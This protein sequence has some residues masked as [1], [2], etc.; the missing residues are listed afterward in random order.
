MRKKNINHRVGKELTVGSYDYDGLAHY[1]AYNYGYKSTGGSRMSTSGNLL[2]SYSAV[3]ATMHPP[4]RAGATPFV[5]I[6]INK[7]TPTTA[8]HLDCVE[9]AVSHMDHMRVDDANPDGKSDHDRN[10]KVMFDTAMTAS[11]K[12]AR[13]RS[14]WSINSHLRTYYTMVSNAK[15]YAQYFKMRNNKY[16]KRLLE[17]PDPSGEHSVEELKLIKD[18]MDKAEKAE[19][20]KRIRDIRKQDKENTDRADADLQEWLKGAKK[21]PNSHYLSQVYIRV[22]GAVVETTESAS[23]SLKSCVVAFLKHKDG[24]LKQGDD[25]SGFTFG[26]VHE[27]IAHIGCHHV[28]MK[29][30][31]RLLKGRK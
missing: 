10:L 21:M 28:P 30:I 2:Y 29:E 8:R 18:K 17:L 31:E 6:N 19:E 15:M 14:E 11:E 27:G 23:I 7:W 12:Y 24:K 1:W 9:S 13:A 26:G 16:Y 4:I 3:V 22:K 5:L 20:A 25:I